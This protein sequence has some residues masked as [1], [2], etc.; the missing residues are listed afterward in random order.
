MRKQCKT[1][2]ILGETSIGP[3]HIPDFAIPEKAKDE[4]DM[5]PLPLRDFHYIAGA[6]A[7]KYF[8]RYGLEYSHPTAFTL[9]A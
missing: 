4:N 5:L 1:R 9:P 7:R 6:W 3:H 2:G 8:P